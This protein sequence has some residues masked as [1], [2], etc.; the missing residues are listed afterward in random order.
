MRDVVSGQW[1]VVRPPCLRSDSRPKSVA[2]CPRPVPRAGALAAV[3]L[4]AGCIG[5]AGCGYR[6]VGAAG[7]GAIPAKLQKLHIVPFVNQTTRAELGQR[8][9]EEITQEWVRRGRFQLVSSPDEADAVLSG[10]ITAA[11]VA[12]VRFDQQGRATEYQLSVAADVKFVDRT[13]QKPVVLWHDQKF[14]RVLSYEVDASLTNY[15]DREVQAIEQL[16]RE[17]ARGLVVTILEGF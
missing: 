16:S 10:T 14:T 13:G 8:L 6:L 2:R 5:L 15:F 7:A 3:V 11:N 4:L 12:P 1:S 9:T 17:L